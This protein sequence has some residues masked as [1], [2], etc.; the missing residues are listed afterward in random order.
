MLG[1]EALPAASYFLLMLIVPESPRWLVLHKQQD[2]ARLILQRITPAAR[3]ESK[4]V[5]ITDSAT[6]ALDPIRTRVRKLFR[7]ELRLILV[8]GL[9]VGIAQQVSGINSVY[10]YAPTIFEQ[11]GVGTN[12]AFAQATYIGI[13]NI[14][15]T[16]LAMLTI[17]RFGR[18]PL[19]LAGLAG[20]V[21]SMS[22]TGYGFHKATYELSPAAAEELATRIERPDLGQLA[23][24]AFANDL[25]YKNAVSRIIGRSM[26]RAN[27]STIIEA[28]IQMNPTIVLIGILGFVASFAFS[29]GPVMWVLF[30]EIFPNSIRGVSMSVMGVINSGVSTAVQFVFPWE[31]ANLGTAMTFF[32]YAAV[33][34]LCLLLL[35][36]LLPETR[37]RTLE[38]LERELTGR[39]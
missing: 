27:E 37:G 39:A 2:R 13:I 26:L 22:I 35:V 28:A 38:E 9:I 14:V 33:A 12:A 19:L 15:F 8:V 31:L 24:Q 23:G 5:E 7:P 1:L 32:I 10:F 21:I 16:V 4:L 17:D 18:R 11:S 30:S 36:R 20:V 25:E 3:L 29:L 6:G 34:L